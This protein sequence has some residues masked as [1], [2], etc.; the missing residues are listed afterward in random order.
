MSILPTDNLIIERSGT[1]YKAPVSALPSG[2]G[3]SLAGLATI[4][5]TTQRGAYEHTETVAA[6]GVTAL[7]K[8]IIGLSPATDDDENCAELLDLVSCVADPATDTL[9][10][11]ATFSQPTSGAIKFNWSAF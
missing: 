9:A 5:I 10:I 6:T 4:T 11:T 3:S 7:S 2:G 8:V 1:H